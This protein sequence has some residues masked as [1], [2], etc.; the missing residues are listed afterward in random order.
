MH[1]NDKQETQDAG[2]LLGGIYRKEIKERDS[3]MTIIYI[4]NILFL[5]LGTGASIYY[6][7]YFFVCLQYSSYKINVE[8][9]VVLG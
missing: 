3:I 5:K 7:W 2:Y 4:D 9:K 6:S 8:E 1:G